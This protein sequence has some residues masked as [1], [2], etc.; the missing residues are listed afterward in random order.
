MPADATIDV[1][2]RSTRSPGCVFRSRVRTVAKRSSKVS[3]RGYFGDR[4]LS[5]G[6]VIE[7]RV[8]APRSIGRF[9]SFTMRKDRKTPVPN[10]G[11]LAADAINVVACP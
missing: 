5:R 4:P 1:R 7:V 9:I 10:R 3:V 2:C 6:A 11:C 8:S